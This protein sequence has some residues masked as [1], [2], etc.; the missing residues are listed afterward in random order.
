MRKVTL[1]HDG[2]QCSAI[3]LGCMGMSEFYGARD[4][5]QSLLT[6]QRA[7][8]LGVTLFDTSNVYGRGHNEEL[9]GRFMSGRRRDEVVIATKF[10]I[11]R[12]PN[13]PLGSAYDRDLDNS[14]A[15]M[16]SCLEGS[17]RRLNTDFVDLYYL[18][19]ADPAIPIEQTV[20]AMAALVKEGKVRG[21]GLSEVWPETLRRAQSVHPIAA[22]QSEYSLWTREP[23]LAVLP[24]CRE[25][26]ITFVAYSPLGRGMFTD[27]KTQIDTVTGN[28]IRLSSPRFRGENLQRNETLLETVKNLAV[29]RCCSTGQVALA[30]LLSRGPDVLPIPGT[31]RVAYLEDNV[32]A[33]NVTLEPEDLAE[34]EVTF[35]IGAAAGERYDSTFAGNAPA[36]RA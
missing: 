22:L 36:P 30:W 28:D 13:G 4:D 29:R 9:L 7:F 15:Y 35:P 1:G 18:H 2:L 31:K 24:T 11:V 10:G 19:R 3:G 6:L 20:E 16:R 34:L 27:R 23:E 17:L 14:P 12:D 26:G 33:A 25:L 21:I 8:D 5:A 32:G